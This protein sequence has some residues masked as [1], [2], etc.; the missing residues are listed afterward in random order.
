M[1]VS[2]EGCKSCQHVAHEVD[3]AALPARTEAPCCGMKRPRPFDPLRNGVMRGLILTPALECARHQSSDHGAPIT[4]KPPS[5]NERIVAVVSDGKPRRTADLVA[6]LPEHRGVR[7]ALAALAAAGIID[8][9][10]CGV[11][12]SPARPNSPRNINWSAARPS[13]LRRESAKRSQ[14]YERRRRRGAG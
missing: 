10:R 7:Q 6:A 11:Y 5:A 2:R 3:A 4:A 12:K 1:I 14:D 8:R 13:R 9:V